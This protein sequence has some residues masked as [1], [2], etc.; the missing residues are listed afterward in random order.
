[1][2]SV[3][4]DHVEMVFALNLRILLGDGGGVEELFILL[5]EI[6][7]AFEGIVM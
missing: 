4:A 5:V 3:L 6:L 1:M 7:P 2:L